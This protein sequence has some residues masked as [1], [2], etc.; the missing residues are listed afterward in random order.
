MPAEGAAREAPFQTM[1]LP[2]YV[3]F[4]ADTHRAKELATGLVDLSMAGDARDGV[5][6]PPVGSF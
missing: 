6:V 3:H 1:Q 4:A 5:H 2:L